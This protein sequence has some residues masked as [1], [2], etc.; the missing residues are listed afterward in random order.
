MNSKIIYLRSNIQTPKQKLIFFLLVLIIIPIQIYQ[1]IFTFS[2]SNWRFLVYL[3]IPIYLLILLPVF[4]RKQL[5]MQTYILF[6][7]KSFEYKASLFRNAEL[8]QYSDIEHIEIKPTEV[9]VD[10]KHKKMSIKTNIADYKNIR[11]IKSRFQ[12]I[13]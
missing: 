11:E 3:S 7:D 8:G 9:L 1:G 6:N 5:W 4:F 2:D 13:K 10:T 12:S